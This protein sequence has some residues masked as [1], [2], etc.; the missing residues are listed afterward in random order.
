MNC[1]LRIEPEFRLLTWNFKVK[2]KKYVPLIL[3]IFFLNFFILGSFGSQRKHDETWMGLYI[4]GI[5]IGHSYSYKEKIDKNHKTLTRIY[6][7]ARMK[8]SRLEGNPVEMITVEEFLYD[9][10]DKPVEAVVKTKMSEQEVVVRAKI[11]PDSIAFSMG[12]RIVK[13][14]PVEEPFYLEVPVEKLIEQNKFKKGT[15]YNCKILDPIAYS[16]SD[17]RYEILGKEKILVLGR[18]YELWHTKSK[19]SSLVP[20]V[21]EEWIDDKGELYK[22]EIQTGFMNITSLKMSQQRALQP[23]EKTVDMALSTVVRIHTE[24]ENSQQIQSMRVELSGLSEQKIDDFPWDGPS[25]KIVEKKENSFILQTESVIFREEEALCFPANKE[26]M[27]SHLKSTLFC[28]SDDPEIKAAAQKIVGEEKNSWKAAK[29]IVDWVRKE[30]KP[31]YDVGF[32]SANEI[33]KNREG[34]CSEYTVLFTALCRSIGIPARANVGIMY[35]EEFFAYHM[36]PEVFV[37]QWIDLDP[38]WFSVDQSTGEY[39]TDATH[40]K[41]GRTELDEN[42]FKE[43]VLSAS[44]LI[45][46]LNIHIIEYR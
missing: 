7:E 2:T 6:S 16:I 19:L 43:M 36:W 4:Q 17:C 30:I 42:L 44:E 41:F 26:E 18:S 38:K 8:V 21:A 25:Q 29:K 37:G 31:S 32:A 12:G 1:L 34:D 13:E 9:E 39:Y 11:N 35:G 3:F 24:L 27:R 14:I 45:G 15:V 23:S 28:Q 22:S 33:L 10:R 5:K 40:I 46:K 20:V